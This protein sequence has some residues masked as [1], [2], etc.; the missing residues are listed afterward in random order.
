[1]TI[2]GNLATYWEFV[3]SCQCRDRG[4]WTILVVPWMG[5]IEELLRHSID[6]RC[7]SSRILFHAYRNLHVCSD[8]RRW[9]DSRDA[10]GGKWSCDCA[11]K[12]TKKVKMSEALHTNSLVQ[13]ESTAVLVRARERERERSS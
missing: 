13:L 12:M 9:T 1:M 10:G 2:G 3:T 6:E 7:V 11:S 5:N 4:G 8:A